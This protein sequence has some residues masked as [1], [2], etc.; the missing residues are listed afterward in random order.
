MKITCIS[1]SNVEGAREHSASTRACELI[2]ELVLESDAAAQVEIL[3]LIDFEM[4]SCRMCGECLTGGKCT[5]DGA[6][7]QVY[8]Q[9]V[10]ADALFVVCPHYA[11]LPSKM[12]ILLEKLEEMA[13]LNWCQNEAY[14]SPLYKKPVGLVAHGGQTAEALPYYKT[15]LLDPLAMAF[16]SVQMRVVGVDEP[17]PNGVV[18]G[19]QNL[20]K[21]PDSIFVKIE[22][23][24]G[25]V[26]N[27]LA[28]LV[29]N[30]LSRIGA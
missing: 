12:M 15:A 24:W 16:A 8:A 18:F 11:P 10:G 1:A 7:N 3:P 4:K 30:T 5:R 20:E 6:F 25:E 26:R 28:P 29:K 14:R 17:W 27:R 22:H 19:I 21:V 9:L 13:Y 2:R 23:D